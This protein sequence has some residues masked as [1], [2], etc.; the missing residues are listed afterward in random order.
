MKRATN[1]SRCVSLLDARRSSGQSTRVELG[2]IAGKRGADWRQI[3]TN[4]T[5]VLQSDWPN[6]DF[7][8]AMRVIGSVRSTTSVAVLCH[9]AAQQSR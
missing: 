2:K 9:F 6:D 4:A 8:V 3:A 1:H 7:I 5:A